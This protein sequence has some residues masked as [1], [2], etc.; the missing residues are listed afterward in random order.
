MTRILIATNE[1]WG[2][3]HLTP[4]VH[5]ALDAGAELVHVVPDLHQAAAVDPDGP[6][7][8]TALDDLL[9]DPAGPA[10]SADLLVVT[11]ATRWP[12]E[13]A[14]AFP[15]LPVVAS[16]LAYMQP[17]PG[18]A[19]TALRE[20]ITTVTAASTGDAEAF[21]AHL[22]LSTATIG[23]PVIVG[24]PLLDDLPTRP[25]TEPAAHR[26]VHQALV[27]TS[28]TRSDATGDAAPG[29]DLLQRVAAGL[30]TSGAHVRVRLHPRE[31]PAL[32]SRFETCPHPLLLDSLTGIDLAVMIPGT[33]APLAAAADVPV[34]AV[35]VEGMAV[36]AHIA[37]VCGAWLTADH[38][39][40]RWLAAGTPTVNPS[41]QE[42]DHAVGPIGGAAGR[43]L[44]ACANKRRQS[45]T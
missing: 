37:A 18:E 19:A 15:E 5:A 11:G 45:G 12:G 27:L 2:T 1:P 24:S 17:T 38:E 23:E 14:A 41:A 33:A 9:T 40:D 21:L 44:G 10:T 30:A 3:Y 35:A 7:Q 39:A 16:C 22:D 8:V 13:V 36:P 43:L 34:A 4:L 6:L 26:R 32:W 29:T 20:R 28:V 25:R 31:D 42:L